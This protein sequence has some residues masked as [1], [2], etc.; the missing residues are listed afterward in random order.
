M[1]KPY[2]LILHAALAGLEVPLDRCVMTGDRL[3]T[4]I[5]MALDAGMKAAIVFTGDSRPHELTDAHEGIF[6]LDRIDQLLP[7][8][9]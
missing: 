7:E 2:P 8:C 9:G 5:A 1:G 4:D 6:Q 3:A